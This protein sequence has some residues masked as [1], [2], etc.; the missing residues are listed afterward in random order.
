MSDRRGAQSSDEENGTGTGAGDGRGGGK[1]IDR[2]MRERGPGVGRAWAA[3]RGG[4]PKIPLLA[5][6]REGH[7]RSF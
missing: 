4:L 3:P 7:R 2:Q 1:G 6:I 5:G